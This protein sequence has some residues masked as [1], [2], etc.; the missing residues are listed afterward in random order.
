MLPNPLLSPV[1]C[2]DT[3]LDD[4]RV[5]QQRRHFEAEAPADDPIIRRAKIKHWRGDPSEH[6]AHVDDRR[7]QREGAGPILFEE[8]R[9]ARPLGSGERLFDGVGEN[10]HGLELVRTVVA[11]AVTHLKFA[12]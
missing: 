9:N 7:P 11:P 6:G 2:G 1:R 3:D 10:L 4:L 5:R 12:R 8:E